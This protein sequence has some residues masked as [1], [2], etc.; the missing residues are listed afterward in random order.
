MGFFSKIFT[1]WDGATIGTSLFSAFNGEHVG[2]DAQG[3]KYY[4]IVFSSARN[5]GTKR[6]G[7]RL[8]VTPVVVDTAGKITTYAALYL[9]NQPETED[10][11]SPA[12][13]TLVIPDEVVK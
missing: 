9:W 7:A 2:T 10:N 6:F 1:W 5:N 4:F 13:D 8:Y 11:H 3:N 12:W